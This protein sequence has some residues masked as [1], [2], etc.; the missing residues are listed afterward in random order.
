MYDPDLPLAEQPA[1]DYTEDYNRSY[2]ARATCV[3]AVG[4]EVL[5]FSRLEQPRQIPTWDRLGRRRTVTVTHCIENLWLS[6]EAR[7]D[8][9]D[10]AC[11]QGSDYEYLTKTEA[12]P[13]LREARRRD[14]SLFKCVNLH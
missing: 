2:R 7:P 11:V 13:F 4:R 8:T 10:Y 5:V 1:I 3:H 6:R 14:G 9:D 12:R